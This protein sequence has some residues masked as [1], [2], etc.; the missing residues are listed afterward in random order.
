MTDKKLRRM[1]IVS[2]PLEQE[3]SALAVPDNWI[4]VGTGSACHCWNVQKTSA[5]LFTVRGSVC[6]VGSLLFDLWPVSIRQLQLDV[7]VKLYA[8]PTAYSSTQHHCCIFTRLVLRAPHRWG[9]GTSWIMRSGECPLSR[10]YSPAAP[11]CGTMSDVQTDP[12]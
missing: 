4:S 9:G 8:R 2:P 6:G 10:G 7:N 3:R 5:H 11:L 1:I 12:Y